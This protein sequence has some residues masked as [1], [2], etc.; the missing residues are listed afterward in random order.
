M[1]GGQSLSRHLLIHIP[2][3]SE[4]ILPEKPLVFSLFGKLVD[5][6]LFITF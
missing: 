5:D 4:R 2:H 3:S 6:T 1:L